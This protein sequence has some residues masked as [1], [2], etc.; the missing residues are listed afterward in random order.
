MLPDDYDVRNAMLG[1]L[2]QHTKQ[3]LASALSAA[4]AEMIGLLENYLD[5]D[6]T[7]ELRA[8]SSMGHGVALEAARTMP[9]SAREGK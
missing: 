1:T 4:P 8:S 3:W 2:H 5:E 9:V 7:A 6:K